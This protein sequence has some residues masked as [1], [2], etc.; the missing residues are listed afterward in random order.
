MA[1]LLDDWDKYSIQICVAFLLPYYHCPP[2]QLDHLFIKAIHLH[3]LYTSGNTQIS[4]TWPVL[5]SMLIKDPPS[6]PLM[7]KLIIPLSNGWM[8]PEEI[9]VLAVIHHI[10]LIAA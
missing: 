9:R 1:K 7:H 2:C 3:T 6:S 10:N 4:F 8:K 5:M